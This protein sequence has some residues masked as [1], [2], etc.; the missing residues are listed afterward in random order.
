MKSSARWWWVFRVGRR[1]H[2]AGADVAEP[3]RHANAIR[4]DEIP[5]VVITRGPVV[6]LR[7]PFAARLSV[8][9]RVGKE[10]Q[11]DNPGRLAV[12]G[13]HGHRLA[14]G[15]NLNALVLVRVREWV[16]TAVAVPHVQPQAVPVRVRPG[17]LAEAR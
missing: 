1:L 15:A 10:S 7:V 8:E 9:G 13:A 3:A 17:R 6:P 4:L 12:V 11:A 2:R 5:R 16:R 14:A